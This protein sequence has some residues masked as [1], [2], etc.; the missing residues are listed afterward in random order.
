M[1]KLLTGCLLLI[2]SVSYAMRCGGQLINEGTLTHQVLERCGKPH[3]IYSDVFNDTTQ[4]IYKQDDGMTYTI[5]VRKNN[6]K[7]ITYVRSSI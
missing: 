2:S 6:V 7:E 3:Y 5:I 4:L 1:R